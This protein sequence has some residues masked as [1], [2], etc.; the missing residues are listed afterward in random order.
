[1]EKIKVLSDCRGLYEQEIL[2]SILM[3]RGIND[4]DKFI[5]PTEDDILPYESLP[6]IDKAVDLL[7]KMV[8]ENKKICTLSDTDSDGISSGTTMTRYLRDL[9]IDADT[10]IDSG[11]KHGLDRRES[12]YSKLTDYNLLIIVDSLNSSTDEYQEL[13]EHGVQIIVLDHHEVNPEIPY[14]KYITLVTSATTY[15][16]HDLSGSG[17]TW[18][19]C[20]YYDI[21]Y[22]TDFADNYLDL[23]ATGIV[24]D[25]MS[26]RVPENRYL[27]GQGLAKLNNLCMKKMV[28]S[29]EFNSTAV[30]FSVAPMVNAANRM[31]ENAS[32]LDAFLSDDNKQVLADLRVIKKAR[33]QQNEKVDEEVPKAEKQFEDQKDSHILFFQLE[34]IGGLSGLIAQKLASKYNRPSIVVSPCDGM[35]KGSGRC[36]W[37][38]PLMKMINDSGLAKAMGH[39]QS[40]GFEINFSANIDNF[41]S[42]MNKQLDSIELDDSI[43]VDVAVN[44]GDLTFDLESKIHALDFVSGKGWKPITFLVE[45][46]DNYEVTTMKDGKHLKLSTDSVDYIKWNSTYSVEEFEDA[47]LMNIPIT[48]IGTLSAGGWAYKKLQLICD[49]MIIQN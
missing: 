31:S 20:K 39:P 8:T 29:Y 40:F 26:M 14:D 4:Y 33:Q 41:I 9:G 45:D 47:S 19:F 23:C 27:V 38:I 25:V 42:T 17:V 32:I 34:G 1:M 21:K 2:Q 46:I 37:D 7:H 36:P 10:F 22:D 15:E 16:N 48:C 12:Y 24:A 49:H 11:K 43:V 6:N 35:L 30:S 13:A 5:N 44:Q 3:D 18:K 28:G